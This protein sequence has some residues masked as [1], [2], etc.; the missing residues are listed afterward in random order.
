MNL[1]R[2]DNSNPNSVQG[3]GTLAPVGSDFHSLK[4]AASLV[5]GPALKGNARS[6]SPAAQNK[7]EEDS[8]LRNDSECSS[9]SEDEAPA[10]VGRSGIKAIFS[11]GQ[12]CFSL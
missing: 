3:M 9:G 6:A 12:K 1:Y 11:P 5:F 8:R 7:A 2:I 4:D 10:S